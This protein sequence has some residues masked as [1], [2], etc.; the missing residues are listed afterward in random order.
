MQSKL[1]FYQGRCGYWLCL[2]NYG[3]FLDKIEGY[4]C[5]KKVGRSAPL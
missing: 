4:K 2:W 1:I 5:Y 3:T